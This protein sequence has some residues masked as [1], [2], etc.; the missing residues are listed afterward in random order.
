MDMSMEEGE[1]SSNFTPVGREPRG[2]NVTQEAK[3]NVMACVP[4]SPPASIYFH[5]PSLRIY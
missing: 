4:A 5:I 3:E 2:P 1:A